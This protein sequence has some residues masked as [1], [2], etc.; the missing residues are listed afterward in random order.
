MSAI[1]KRETAQQLLSRTATQIKTC[2]STAEAPG[3][4]SITRR[5]SPETAY[6]RG[7]GGGQIA[8]QN[9]EREVSALQSLAH[10]P[11]CCYC[12]YGTERSLHSRKQ[13]TNGAM[14]DNV[15]CCF[16]QFFSRFEGWSG[17]S[18]L[19]LPSSIVMSPNLCLLRVLT[20]V[21]NNSCSTFL[22]ATGPRNQS[23]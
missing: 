8:K 11:V 4:A 6:D 3:I 17:L 19:A 22:A 23:G 16:P 15:P 10:I 18:V 12:T 20:A 13:Q 1:S 21:T 2:S 7:R 5:V 14:I 9:I